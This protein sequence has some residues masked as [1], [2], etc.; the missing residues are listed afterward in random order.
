MNETEI[1]NRA[2]KTIAERGQVYGDASINLDRAAAGCDVIAR[3]ALENG[4]RI[5]AAHLVLI[6]DWVKTCRLLETMGHED[7]WV[8]KAGYSAIGGRIAN[9]MGED[10]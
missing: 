9:Q 2:A 4:G 3:A 10:K 8:D 5:T 1:L 7:S 6:Q